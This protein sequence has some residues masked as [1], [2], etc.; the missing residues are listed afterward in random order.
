MKTA[1]NGGNSDENHGSDDQQDEII[2]GEM[3]GD[4]DQQDDQNKGD[5][6][7]DDQDD[8]GEVV[9]TVGEETPPQEEED[10]QPAPVWVKELRKADK[11]KARKIRE[12]EAQLAQ[13]QV[14]T[15]T[16]A[17]A[18]LT[19]PT[20]ADCNYDE[21]EFETKLIDYNAQ[22][23][24]A[25]AEQKKAEDA[26]KAADAAWQASVQNYE[27]KKGALKVPDYE[28]REVVAKET[29]SITQQGIILTGAKNSAVVMYALGKNPEKLKEFAAITDPVK[30]CFAIAQWEPELKVTPRKAP[31]PPERQVRG[32]APVPSGGDA[33]LK[34][35]R[36]EAVKSGDLSKVVAYKRQKQA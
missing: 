7:D 22:Q 21:A 28:D 17:P 2:T 27:A 32:S 14:T 6:A 11:E 15:E 20:L 30:F 10:H 1:E 18:K 12:L 36:E 29:L 13:K 4:D 19:R 26:R 25:Q 35:L 24:S 33:T 8:E 34:R 31:P 9:V 5:G 23:Q 16:A 3:P